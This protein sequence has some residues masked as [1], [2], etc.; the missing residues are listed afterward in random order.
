MTISSWQHS[1]QFELSRGP[2]RTLPRAAQRRPCPKKH[3]CDAAKIYKD[4][5]KVQTGFRPLSPQSPCYSEPGGYG[6]LVAKPTSLLLQRGFETKMSPEAGHAPA[7]AAFW[8]PPTNL[9]DA[10]A[11][12]DAHI[13]HRGRDSSS[14]G[15][16]TSSCATLQTKL[17][18][19]KARTQ[20]PPKGPQPPRGQA[21]AMAWWLGARVTMKVVPG[22]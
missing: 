17:P 10:R 22:L 7:R 14:Q 9:A 15:P 18:R 1:L 21:G 11:A 19:A 4:S 5:A 13:E 8:P 16:A 12:R 2:V 20:R 3:K 6:S